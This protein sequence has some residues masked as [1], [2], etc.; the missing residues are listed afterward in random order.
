MTVVELDHKTDKAVADGMTTTELVTNHVIEIG[1]IKD[2][3]GIKDAVPKLEKGDFDWALIQLRILSLGPEYTYPQICPS[4]KCKFQGTYSHDL[5]EL[6]VID[7][8]DPRERQIEYDSEEGHHVV[9]RTLKAQDMQDLAELMKDP[10]D[11]IT[12][13]LALQLVSIDD[14]TPEKALKDK[15]RKCKN[16]AQH[17]RQATLMMNNIQLPHREKE[18]IRKKIRAL[19]GFPD[20][21]VRG[22]CPECGTNFAHL[23]PIDYT[24]IVPSL[25]EAIQHGSL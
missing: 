6:E 1:S 23:L 17:V 4:T 18:E 3:E 8:P 20:R 13:I 21:N 11:Q 22:V 2:L 7:M 25:E 24:F 5:E 10:N 12:R 15:G 14:V 9:L 16:A 19:I